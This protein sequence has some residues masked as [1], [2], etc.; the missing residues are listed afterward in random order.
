METASDVTEAA[1]TLGGP[2]VLKTAMPGHHHKSDVDGVRLGIKGKTALLD[3]WQEM[4][5]RLGPRTLV[6]PMAPPGV[7][8]MFGLVHDETFGPLVL[9]AAGGVLAEIMDDSLLAVPPL[10]TEA[11]LDLIDGLRAGRLLDGVRGRPAS[12]RRALAEMLARF[13]VLVHCLG[14]MIAELDLNPVIAGANGA[15]AVD[16]LVVPNA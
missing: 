9:V 14:D 6:A 12:D 7:E 11:A 1:E 8:M 5:S 13:S 15:I 2:L 16:A 10:D 4:A 3:A